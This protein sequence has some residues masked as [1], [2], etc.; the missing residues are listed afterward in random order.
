MYR[1][2]GKI[3]DKVQSKTQFAEKYI[4]HFGLIKLLVLEKVKKINRD[5]NTFLL[6]AN[7]DPEVMATPSKR[8]SLISKVKETPTGSSK[9]RERHK[10]IKKG[11][12]KQKVVDD[13]IFKQ[14]IQEDDDLHII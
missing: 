1:S 2:L 8:V 10:E 6:I 3:V 4:F 13:T 12:E 9:K 11:K 14:D 5:W 7:Y